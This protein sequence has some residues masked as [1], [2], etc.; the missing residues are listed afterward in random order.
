MYPQKLQIGDTVRIIA[1][2]SSLGIISKENRKVSNRRFQE[3][4][5]KVE[6]GKHVE[7]ID[8]FSSSS[9]Q[10]R[11]DD[12][13]A[14]FQDPD[15]KAVFAVVGGFNTNQLLDYIDWNLI[16]TN[17]KIFCGFSDITALNNAIYTKTGLANYSGP[18][19]ASLGKPRNIEYSI[20][21]LKKCLFSNELYEVQP[22]KKWDDYKWWLGDGEYKDFKNEGWQIIQEG[23]AT[24]TII[25]ANLCTLNL[26]QG[27]QYFPPLD[28]AIL[29]L[30]D[31]YES[32]AFNFDRDLQSLIHLPDFHKVKGIVIGR[33]ELASKVTDSL[34]DQIIKTKK[35][36]QGLPVISGVDFGHT[37]PMTTF[38]IG[39]EVEINAISAN[40]SIVITKH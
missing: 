16:K 19:Y 40:P 14:A 35:E 29:F 1:P 34:L 32:S 23:E 28:D 8:E 38:P 21:Y 30:E 33:F 39:G 37:S 18:A 5:L 36:L 9:I 7:E 31:D 27:T 11:V 2:A 17:P 25:G 26:L 4:G 13:H 3:L 10:S 12:L 6:L 22:S 20:E 15:V 24:G